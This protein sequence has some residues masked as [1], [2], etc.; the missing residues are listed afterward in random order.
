MKIN[1]VTRKRRYKGAVVGLL[2]AALM[3]VAAVIFIPSGGFGFLVSPMMGFVV[4]TV[5]RK[6]AG[7]GLAAPAAVAAA[8]G[9]ALGRLLVGVPFLALLTPRPLI[10]AGLAAAAAAFA[11]SR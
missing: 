8:C 6:T 9:L 7:A 1:P 3:A 2:A 4:G 11:A 10:S 5:V